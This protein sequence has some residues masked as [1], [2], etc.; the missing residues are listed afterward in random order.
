VI[1]PSDPVLNIR[2]KVSQLKQFYTLFRYY[3]YQEYLDSQTFINS[4]V[5]LVKTNL[6]PLRWR[7]LDF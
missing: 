3:A 7:Y 5:Y 2:L 1:I 4:M 6:V